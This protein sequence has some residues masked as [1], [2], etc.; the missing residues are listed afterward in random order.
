M[1]PENI[2]SEPVTLSP[3]EFDVLWEHLRL[4]P[5][6]VVLRVPSPGRTHAERAQLVERAWCGI[7]E[8]GLG[9]PAEL[10]PLLLSQLKTLGHP[11][12]EVDGRAWVG[13]ETRV[14]AAAAGE[15][16]VRATLTGG[17]LSLLSASPEGLPDAVIDA[18][19]AQNAGSGY[20]VTLPT[21]DFEKAAFAANGTREGFTT[22]LRDRGMREEDLD[23]LVEMIA[24]L[25]GQGQFGAAA[26]DKFGR[27]YR[28]GR[29]VAF[30][31]TPAGR[32]VQITRSN[33]GSAPWTTISPVD[34]R[35]MSQHVS[36][37]LDEV[38]HTA[39]RQ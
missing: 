6:P 11:D 2:G 36:D 7:E 22:A 15:F 16:A 12:R 23:T 13:S 39:G 37:L 24:N 5:M 10:H 1:I 26:R 34:R 33:G 19:P 35:R 14:L 20:S 31:D 25:V 27:R 28:A 38:L 32:Y 18:L 9:R 4:P 17:A 21:E 8:R 30:F 3:L 29:V